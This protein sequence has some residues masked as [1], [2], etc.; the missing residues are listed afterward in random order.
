MDRPQQTLTQIL[1]DRATLYSSVPAVRADLV[2]RA[3]LA[4][5]EIDIGMQSDIVDDVHILL[6]RIATADK[7]SARMA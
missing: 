2:K 7:R 4:A 3:L 6:D 1:E 5:Y